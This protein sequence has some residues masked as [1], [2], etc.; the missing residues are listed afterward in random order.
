MGVILFKIVFDTLYQWYTC[1]F[2]K[3][4]GKN[5]HIKTLK[6]QSI[7]KLNYYLKK[8]CRETV[9]D[10]CK[11]LW[12][13]IHNTSLLCKRVSITWLTFYKTFT[14]VYRLLLFLLMRVPYLYCSH[15]WRR[16]FKKPSFGQSPCLYCFVS[17]YK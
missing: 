10:K 5:R 8:V 16:I 9:T 7:S 2:L 13:S 11:P 6:H 1:M 3:L 12:H 15:T 14:C 17:S 4:P